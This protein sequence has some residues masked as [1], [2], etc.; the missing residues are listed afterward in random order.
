M[1]ALQPPQR[2]AAEVFDKA[3]AEGV[4]ALVAYSALSALFSAVIPKQQAPGAPWMWRMVLRIMEL[5]VTPPTHHLPFGLPNLMARDLREGALLLPEADALTHCLATKFKAHYFPVLSSIVDLAMAVMEEK[6]LLRKRRR[7]AAQD[8]SERGES[9][10]RDRPGRTELASYLSTFELLKINVLAAQPDNRTLATL[11]PM[12]PPLALLAF[13]EEVQDTRDKEGQAL[14]RELIQRLL[15]DPGVL[16]QFT[17]WAAQQA[18]GSGFGELLGNL[19]VPYR[20][21]KVAEGFHRLAG[22]LG[23]LLDEA[24][25]IEIQFFPWLLQ[26]Y[27]AA[28]REE[29]RVRLKAAA[30]KERR[31]QGDVE[32]KTEWTAA[33]EGV[34]LYAALVG[35]LWPRGSR[36]L[37]GVA[38]LT[39][40]LGRGI[41]RPNEDRSGQHRTLLAALHSA[42]IN[43]VLDEGAEAAAPAARR[44]LMR[45]LKALYRVELRACTQRLFDGAALAIAVQQ[46]AAEEAV[47]RAAEDALGALADGF[48]ETRRLDE[49]L[50]TLLFGERPLAPAAERS[51]PLALLERLREALPAAPAGQGPALVAALGEAVRAAP[52]GGPPRRLRGHGRLPGR[53][54]PGARGDA[55]ALATALRAYLAL[56]ALHARCAALH[57][58]IATLPGQDPRDAGRLPALFGAVPGADASRWSLAALL[59]AAERAGP[60]SPLTAAATE[61]LAHWLRLTHEH[62]LYASTICVVSEQPE[63]DGMISQHATA[64]PPELV[65]GAD[66]LASAAAF[67]DGPLRAALAAADVVRAWVGAPAATRYVTAILRAALDGGHAC[68]AAAR[69]ARRR[70]AV[71]ASD[72][73]RQPGAGLCG[74]P[75]HGRGRGAGA[76]PAESKVYAPLLDGVR[77][78]SEGWG[79]CWRGP[80]RGELPPVGGPAGGRLL[81]LLMKLPL[82][83]PSAVPC[84]MAVTLALTSDR[85][86]RPEPQKAGQASSI[87]EPP[88]EDPRLTNVLTRVRSWATIAPGALGALHWRTWM[89]ALLAAVAA[90]PGAPTALAAAA[91]LC[92]AAVAAELLSPDS[93]GSIAET[94]TSLLP[95]TRAPALG[96]LLLLQGALRASLAALDA[97]EDPLER[98]QD[99]YLAPAAK[100]RKCTQGPVADLLA[101]LVECGADAARRL[102]ASE[103]AFGAEER[104]HAAVTVALAVR[105]ALHSAPITQS[106]VAV[107]QVN[108]LLSALPGALAAG[109]LTPGNENKSALVSALADAAATATAHAKAPEAAHAASTLAL[110]LFGLERDLQ[111]VAA[112]PF[113]TPVPVQRPRYPEV[114]NTFPTA[115]EPGRRA[116]L[117]GLSAFL[118]ASS[119]FVTHSAVPATVRL[120]RE[121]AGHDNK[122]PSRLVIAELALAVV[123]AAV[124]RSLGIRLGE[125]L[126][127]ALCL[128]VERAALPVGDVERPVAPQTW[129]RACAGI[130]F[131]ASKDAIPDEGAALAAED[132]EESKVQIDLGDVRSLKVWA[133]TQCSQLW[134]LEAL[135]LKSRGRALELGPGSQTLHALLAALDGPRSLLRAAHGCK[136]PERRRFAGRC[137]AAVIAGVADAITATIRRHAPATPTLIPLIVLALRRTLACA[138]SLCLAKER[139]SQ[140]LADFIALVESEPAYDSWMLMGLTEA[141]GLPAEPVRSTTAGMAMREGAFAIYGACTP[142]ELQF[143]F[144]LLGSRQGNILE[145]REALAQLRRDFQQQHQYSGKI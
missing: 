103:P 108:A 118:H 136:E 74:G 116:L 2:L 15:M 145:R 4:P 134:A 18:T 11:T 70:P 32:E 1:T 27:A 53:A 100:K 68:H 106:S 72:A 90:R 79:R 135:S 128:A 122:A 113:Q 78:P 24:P 85:L 133:L 84:A 62:T 77:A 22:A 99:V 41:Y 48:G 91:D 124:P 81:G 59:G 42:A 82:L 67:G 102:G 98:Y 60:A 31:W 144:Y 14:A 130:F 35:L 54:A 115:A 69:R 5:D 6:Y 57:P 29:E 51:L 50:Q 119:G 139:L 40:A 143:V 34:V 142:D 86:L 73:G 7:E 21:G 75:A 80:W 25:G 109:L 33:H 19:E 76:G 10:H 138:A 8:A 127:S 83:P 131:L 141:D 46:T 117:N 71:R 125:E 64:P 23:W 30:N 140:L 20:E 110:L 45:V 123:G 66:S 36:A 96:Q 39:E 61:A 63:S 49:L 43:R 3:T 121:A 126:L 37:T 95:K 93:S 114:A 89:G 12:L 120:L 104:A 47:R 58:G 94:L 105:L 17:C 13:H 132:A 92:E 44:G 88:R 129:I 87:D 101:L 65:A 26:S 9:R 97:S 52:R 28:C 38:E 107:K 56:L 112:D 137:C 111:G 55:A 16:R